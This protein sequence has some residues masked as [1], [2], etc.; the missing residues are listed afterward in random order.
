MKN[1]KKDTEKKSSNRVTNVSISTKTGKISGNLFSK[2]SNNIVVKSGQT[3]S[4]RISKPK[5]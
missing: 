2:K 4:G 1:S 5:K 3:I